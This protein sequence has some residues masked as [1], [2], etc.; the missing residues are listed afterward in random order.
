MK[1]NNTL[2]FGW[3]FL[4]LAWVMGGYC[5]VG[6]PSPQIKCQGAFARAEFC[7]L[8]KGTNNRPKLQQHTDRVPPSLMALFSLVALLYNTSEYIFHSTERFSTAGDGGIQ[9]TCKLDTG[10][11]GT[12]LNLSP[13]KISS[14]QE[15]HFPAKQK[16]H[17]CMWAKNLTPGEAPAGQLPCSFILLCCP[18]SGGTLRPECCSD[19]G[20]LPLSS[21]QNFRDVF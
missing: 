12:S 9:H 8:S 2:S 21:F 18:S 6:E 16:G 10:E 15:I 19:V 3:L 11:C 14:T 20:L 7:T 5:P 1:R 13:A 4:S 17:I